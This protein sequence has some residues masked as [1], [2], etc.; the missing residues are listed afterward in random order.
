MQT[1]DAESPDLKVNENATDLSNHK[2]YVTTLRVN[3]PSTK[4][5]PDVSGFSVKQVGD[6]L[7]E[8]G[9]EMYVVK[10][11]AEMIDG[12]ML[13]FLNDDILRSDFGMNKLHCMKLRK[14][15]EGWRPKV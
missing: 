12:E 11:E 1:I 14:Y 13:T 15:L 6:I 5:A 7:R 8:L 2:V 9:M 3:Q 4:K 10:F